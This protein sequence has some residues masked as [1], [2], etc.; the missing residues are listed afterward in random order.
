MAKKAYCKTYILRASNFRD[1]TKIMKLNTRK[2]SE[3]PVSI[4]V[5]AMIWY[6][7]RKSARFIAAKNEDF[8]SLLVVAVSWDDVCLCKE[9]ISEHWATSQFCRHLMSDLLTSTYLP[10]C[11][12]IKIQRKKIVPFSNCYWCSLYW[13]LFA[14][15]GFSSLFIYLFFVFLHFVN[16]SVHWIVRW[17]PVLKCPCMEIAA[18]WSIVKTLSLKCYIK[19][20][21][22]AHDVTINSLLFW[23]SADKCFLNHFSLFGSHPYNIIAISI[24]ISVYKN[25]LIW[26]DRRYGI[27]LFSLYCYQMWW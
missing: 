10:L 15:C 11:S 12:K 7:T 9:T 1:L 3:L 8:T 4:S 19:I 17:L 22:L 2:F 24:R 27:M 25:V 16:E 23:Y 26:C 18:L 14:V 6:A 13:T 21:L 20:R 5:T